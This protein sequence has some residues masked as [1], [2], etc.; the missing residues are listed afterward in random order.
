[1][2]LCM[3]GIR[4][5]LIFKIL[6]YFYKMKNKFMLI[7]FYFY[8]YH[9]DINGVTILEEKCDIYDDLKCIITDYQKVLE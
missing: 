8:Y 7:L 5:N 9:L 3:F 6:N 1:M 4:I 2:C